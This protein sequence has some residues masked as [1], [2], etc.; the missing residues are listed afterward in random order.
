MT[1]LQVSTTLLKYRQLEYLRLHLIFDTASRESHWGCSQGTEFNIIVPSIPFLPLEQPE[2][3]FSFPRISSLSGE[4]QTRAW[5]RK[6]K[7]DLNWD[8]RMGQNPLVEGSQASAYDKASLHPRC[9]EGGSGYFT[10]VPVRMDPSCPLRSSSCGL[11]GLR[12]CG[13]PASQ[14]TCAHELWETCFQATQYQGD[15]QQW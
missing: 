7:F 9:G 5:N 15:A 1:Q 10:W 14:E 12:A 4:V 11:L 13:N 8:M 2:A 6:E 3:L